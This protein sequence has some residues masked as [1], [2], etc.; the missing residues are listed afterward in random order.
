MNISE[1]FIRR[2]AGTTLLAAG[3]FILGIVAYNFLPV[4]PLPRI[5]IPSISVSANL[6]G[7]NPETVA[8][9]LAAPLERRLSQISGVTELTSTSSLGAVS[10]SVQFDL[11]RDIDSA[12]RDVQA[13]IAA[14]ASE[15]PLNL[16]SPPSY[17]KLNPADAPVMILAM[18]S[19]AISGSAMFEFADEIIGQRLSQVEGVGQV[20][21][22]GAEKSAVR[23]RV[24][25]AALASA[26]LSLEDVRAFL[27][28]INGNLPKGSVESDTATY[29][30]Y[31]NA[32]LSTAEEYRNLIVA[33]RNGIPIRL[34]AIAD[35][36]D[37][38]ENSRVAGWSGISSENQPTQRAVLLMIYKQA[39]ANVI[40]T[41]DAVKAVLPQVMK[42][43][44][45]SIQ[46][47]VLDDRTRTIRASVEE[48]QFSLLLSI[49]LV[50]MV[51][52]LFLRR[53]WPTFI[54]SITVPLALAGT[55]A[56][57]YLFGFSIDNLS[58]M[59]VTISVGF[60]VDDAIVVI[61]NIFRYIEQGE[62]P[63]DAAL[64]G[65]RQIGFTVVS[66]SISLVAVFIPLLFMG[67]IVGRLFHEFAITLCAAILISAVISLTLTPMLCSRFLKA[68][69][70]L[71]KLGLVGRTSERAF[72]WM[73]GLY[74]AG[75]RWVLRHQYVMLGVTALTVVATVWGY[76]LVPKGFFPQQDVG[77]LMGHTE[78]A[79]DISFGAMAELQDRIANM[80]LRDPAV[81]A[82]TSYIGSGISTSSVNNGRIFVTLKPPRERDNAEEV[83]ARLRRSTAGVPGIRLTLTARQD[84]RVG[85]RGTRSQYQYALS[86][87]SLEELNEWAPKVVSALRKIPQL[88][89]V[90]S[91]QQ[92]RG[93]QSIVTIDRDAAARFGVS[94]EEI[95]NTLY[96]AF[97]ERQVSILY[98]RYNQHRTIMEV[99][100]EYRESPDALEKIYVRSTSGQQIPL[101]SV[102][103]FTTGNTSLSVSHQGQFPA[104][105]LS[106]NLEPGT[107]L[108]DASGLITQAVQELRLP[109]TVQ[110]SFQ[111]TA[112]VFQASLTTL[113]LLLI[114]ALLAVYVVLGILYESLIHPITIISTLPS[115]GLGALL[116]LMLTG[117]DLSLVSFIG[118]IL[119]IG[120]VKK[121][122]I[123]MIDF[124]IEAE[125]EELLSPEEAIYQACVIRF[126]PIM[127]TTMAALLGILP[128]A[129]GT[130]I[131]SEL[132]QPLGVAVVGGL[133]V[134]Q[135]LT[136][137]TTPVIYL[138]FEHIRVFF[139]RR[140]MQHLAALPATG[141]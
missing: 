34:R 76:S 123:M 33:Q 58:L 37:G 103:S 26:G 73:L 51:I 119:L 6:P 121:N 23:V 124:A 64:K 19:K 107:A 78:A 127:M 105:T 27:S 118:I 28:S 4:A 83:I 79:Q 3:L 25:P 128:L 50:V 102:A 88:K 84:I 110:A 85:G 70:D 53:F 75:L 5:D 114:A 120:I 67:G 77:S 136:L 116:A 62:R 42:W 31:S 122:A 104:V 49:A 65:A 1:P 38:P 13:A 66:I 48:V 8:S 15:L 139:A 137:Y 60:V 35:I 86:S 41:V 92:L 109:Q 90:N 141:T 95:D 133:I 97:G 131:G 32:Q 39:D 69:K 61:E 14:A 81:A 134:S 100:P 17:R 112:K 99:L 18:R 46:M 36:I 44:P 140:R 115:A 117:Y 94:P 111:G 101:S 11:S 96:S 52:F 47:S 74:T 89:D 132:R 126:R 87:A 20:N 54:A 30:I 80:V 56:L 59:A 130:G 7:A 93:L 106:F 108:G 55:F 135:V 82:I 91:D 40:K 125:R 98:K 10:I 138:M 29:A 71:P 129:I 22:S 21:I 63:F 12:A 68:E 16:P 45:P 113:P 2:P 43:L 24:N 57:M 72:E 9:S